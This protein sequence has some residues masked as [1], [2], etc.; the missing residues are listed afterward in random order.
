MSGGSDPRWDDPWARDDDRATYARLVEAARHES[1]LAAVIVLLGGDAGL[2]CGE[3]LA[4]Q[5]SGVD[6]AQRQLT[7]A[8][9]D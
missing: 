2:R 9:S 4:L 7:V 5:W 8:R 1:T 3:I 6:R